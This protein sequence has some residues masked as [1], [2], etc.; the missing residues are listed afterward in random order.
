ME[1]FVDLPYYK[2]PLK[3]AIGRTVAEAAFRW[4]YWS[5]GDKRFVCDSCRNN[6]G[7]EHET[8]VVNGSR[9]WPKDSFMRAITGISKGYI[10]M[11]E[12][13]LPYETL[14][15]GWLELKLPTERLEH[16]RLVRPARV[17]LIDI[18]R[19][20]VNKRYHLAKYTMDSAA[21]WLFPTTIW[22][23][24]T[25]YHGNTFGAPNV[26]TVLTTDGQLLS[27]RPV[28]RKET[29][30]DP[31][32]LIVEMARK[33]CKIKRLSWAGPEESYELRLPR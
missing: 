10:A 8:F 7:K 23:N 6:D 29:E 21:G 27:S 18:V 12:F 3:F 17:Y 15:S 16:S 20:R 11:E 33:Y 24:A 22:D 26:D 2:K 14:I 5:E 32:R 1:D 31:L 25:D 19:L 30:V 28:M 4:G 9:K 13:K